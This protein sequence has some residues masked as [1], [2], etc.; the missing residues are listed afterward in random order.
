MSQRGEGV[1]RK[2]GQG[3]RMQGSRLWGRGD[4]RANRPAPYL[5]VSETSIACGRGLLPGR[6][7]YP[8]NVQ[9]WHFVTSAKVQTIFEICK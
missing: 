1:G 7:H 6:G 4:G 5:G 2:Q 3:E 8:A 9:A